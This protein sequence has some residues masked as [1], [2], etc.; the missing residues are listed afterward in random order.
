M[1]VDK[2]FTD[3]ALFSSAL[4]RRSLSVAPRQSRDLSR[5]LVKALSITSK[6]FAVMYRASVGVR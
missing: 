4:S 3:T 5:R 2:K 6:R 1:F